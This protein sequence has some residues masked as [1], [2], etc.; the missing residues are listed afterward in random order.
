LSEL[1]GEV[2]LR[3]LRRIFREGGNYRVEQ[4]GTR[5]QIYSKQIKN[6][7]VEY[8]RNKLLNCQVTSE[9]AANALKPVCNRFNLPYT[10][11]DQLNYYA[12]EVLV[13]LV[14]LG[15]AG[16]KKKGRGYLYSIWHC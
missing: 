7:V 14:A 15:K 13:V 2:Q 9:E 8:L 16:I 10:Y 3:N 1:I 12:Q 5:E 11:G 6:E 4:I